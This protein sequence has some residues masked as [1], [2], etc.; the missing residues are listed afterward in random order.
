MSHLTE[1]MFV[2]PDHLKKLVSLVGAKMVTDSAKQV[3]GVGSGV[4]GK[5]RPWGRISWKVHEQVKMAK[6]V[7]GGW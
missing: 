6:A 5:G 4:R 2:R 7:K 3:Q 1:A